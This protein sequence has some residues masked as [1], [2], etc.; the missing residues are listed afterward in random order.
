MLVHEFTLVNLR[1]L[2]LAY[3]A[4]E[5]LT[6][7]R[8]NLNVPNAELVFAGDV[9]SLGVI[10]HVLVN[11]HGVDGDVSFNKSQY[12]VMI[13]YNILVSDLP[14]RCWRDHVCILL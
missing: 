4:P 12:K 2:S 10:M 5:V 13:L 8:Q 1:G 7:F 9:Y 11:I 6:R 14:A 3:A